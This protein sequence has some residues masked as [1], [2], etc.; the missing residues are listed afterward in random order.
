MRSTKASPELRL[1]LAGPAKVRI[2]E[3]VR[4][5]LRVVNEG[6]TPQK[7]SARLNLA[8]GDVRLRVTAPDGA[9]TT[10]RG[11]R[12]IDAAARTVDLQP[13]AALESGLG[14][15]HADGGLVLAGPG[16]YAVVAEF[17]AVVGQPPVTS[18]P[19]RVE[20][21]AAASADDAEL[22]RLVSQRGVARAFELG[23][24]ETDA[25]RKTI[26]AIASGYAGKAE[27]R[28]ARL[29]VAAVDGD[30][31]GLDEAID[32]AIAAEGPLEAARTITALVSPAAPNSGLVREAARA[33][34]ERAPS[35]DAKAAVAVVDTTPQQASD[36]GRK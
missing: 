23:E 17:D 19:L 36:P 28:A 9:V 3:F 22:A 18:A 8:E 2:G 10:V 1:E 12:Q 34:L 35:K 20:V 26:E 31:K 7:I 32:A 30:R 21:R 29:V 4:G 6:T 25:A 11:S 15:L 14:L 5:S 33:R 27:G 13:G 16:T 24:P